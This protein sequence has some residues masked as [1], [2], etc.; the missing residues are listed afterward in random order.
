M[1]IVVKTVI[2]IADYFSIMFFWYIF[3]VS[4]YWFVFFKMQERVYC[5][6]PPSTATDEIGTKDPDF[7]QYLSAILYDDYTPRNSLFF[8][9]GLFKLSYIIYKIAFEQAWWNIFCID[10]ERPKVQEQ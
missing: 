7:S 10:W 9:V 3:G 6:L 5:F 1:Y 2:N 8:F 4:L